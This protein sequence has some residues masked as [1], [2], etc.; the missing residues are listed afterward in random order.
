MNNYAYITLFSTNNYLYGL[1]GLMYSWKETNPKYPFYVVCTEQIS[2]TNKEILK[3]IG[4]NIIEEKTW[5][6]S[7]YFERIDMLRQKP[8]Y[9]VG[10]NKLSLS[11]NGW[12]HCWTKLLL[13]HYTQFDKLLFIDSD[14]WIWQN[15]DDL[16]DK[17]GF[18]SVA[19]IGS[20]YQH[21]LHFTSGFMVIEP[22]HDVANHLIEMANNSD[23]VNR[24]GVWCIRT[25]MDILNDYYSDW[26]YHP[27]LHLPFATFLNWFVFDVTQHENIE[28]VVHNFKNIK[29]IHLIGPKPWLKGFVYANEIDPN[30][31]GMYRELYLWYLRFLNVALTDM[32]NREIAQ[33]PLVRE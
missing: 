14:A 30:K 13:F 21:C 16:F 17:P 3:K 6:P 29:A 28:Y 8:E 25:E 2:D 19:E 27:E 22:N 20:F 7:N 24:R 26:K 4:Y 23:I 1:I 12:Q 9:W 15:L 18:T 10:D 31:W 5:L 11:E 33:L 32:Y